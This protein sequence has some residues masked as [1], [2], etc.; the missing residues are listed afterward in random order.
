MLNTINLVLEQILNKYKNNS[1]N[2]YNWIRYD[3]EEKEYWLEQ[4][5]S[6]TLNKMGVKFKISLTEIKI[7]CNHSICILS[8]SYIIE[9]EP[10][11]WVKE[12]HQY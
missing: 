4:E 3:E 9:K 11:L 2:C 12:L 8:L 7:S 10:Y 1:D 5:I 6:E